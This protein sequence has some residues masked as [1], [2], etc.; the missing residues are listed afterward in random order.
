MPVDL[1]HVVDGDPELSFLLV[2]V[3]IRPH[4]LGIELLGHVLHGLAE[5]GLHAE[6][7]LLH[8]HAQPLD[9]WIEDKGGAVAPQHQLLC[10]EEWGGE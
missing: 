7:L 9:F 8:E 3:V 4:E 10:E 6:V 2:L 5:V 1:G